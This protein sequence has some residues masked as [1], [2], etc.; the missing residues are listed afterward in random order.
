MLHR[1][2]FD[3]TFTLK[4]VVIQVVVNVTVGLYYSEMCAVKLRI[5]N[6]VP[7]T[8][9]FCIHIIQ[10]YVSCFLSTINACVLNTNTQK[11]YIMQKTYNNRF[12]KRL[13]AIPLLLCML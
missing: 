5:H 2:R 13:P 6:K 3:L 12:H 7:S 11:L 4:I 1:F 10:Y 9:H 8:S